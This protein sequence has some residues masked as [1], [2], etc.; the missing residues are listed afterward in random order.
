MEKKQEKL[1]VQKNINIVQMLA[2]F[3]ATTAI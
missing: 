2:L 1:A 3:V